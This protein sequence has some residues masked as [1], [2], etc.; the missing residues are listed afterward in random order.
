MIA[1]WRLIADDNNNF[2]ARSERDKTHASYEIGRLKA[3]KKYNTAAHI[4][5]AAAKKE[6]KNAEQADKGMRKGATGTKKATTPARGCNDVAKGGSKK[7]KRDGDK[8]DDDRGAPKRQSGSA[9]SKWPTL[10]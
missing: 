3:E 9:R 10:V 6:A 8:D 4:A 2:Y 5:D 1:R 7:R